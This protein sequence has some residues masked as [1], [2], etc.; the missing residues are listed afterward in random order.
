MI[1]N[2][3]QDAAPDSDVIV[4]NDHSLLLDHGVSVARGIVCLKQ[5]KSHVLIMNFTEEYQ[6][7]NKSASIAFLEEIQEES[8]VIA[9]V[10]FHR[11]SDDAFKSAH[12]F[13]VNPAL[14]QGKHER[15]RALLRRYSE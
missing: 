8:D 11:E 10:D 15:L 2:Y 7:L 3:S 12:F 6:H 4:E 1:A 5:G 14:P 13:D 9:F